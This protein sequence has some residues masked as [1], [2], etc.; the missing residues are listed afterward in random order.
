MFHADLHIHSRYSRACSKKCDPAAL[1]WWAVRKGV[2]VVGTGDFTHPAWAAE[3]A[4][5]LEPA[6]PG[7][8]RLRPGL[9]AELAGTSP[10]SCDPRVRFLLSAEIS[11]IYQR[12]GITRKFTTWCTPPRSKPPAISARAWPRSGTWHRTAARSL[13]WTPGTCWR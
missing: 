7:L 9:Q 5:T 11:T 3:L 4:E 13:A 10:A 2:T 6:E 8:F 12:D 1:A